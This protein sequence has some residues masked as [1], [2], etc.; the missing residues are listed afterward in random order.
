MTQGVRLIRLKEG[1]K[2]SDVA[3]VVGEEHDDEDLNGIEPEE[4]QQADL[5]DN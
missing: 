2:I 4:T 5:F 3:P 1:D